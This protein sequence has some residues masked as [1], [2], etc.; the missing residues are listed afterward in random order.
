MPADVLATCHWFSIV[1]NKLFQ[2]NN[3]GLVSQVVRTFEEHTI[4]KL[5]RTFA[6][7]TVADATERACS[8][9]VSSLEVE[10]II[11][12]L[13]MSKTLNATLSHL[14][15]TSESAMLRFSGFGSNSSILNEPY[16][17]TRL[18]RGA[19]SMA[20]LMGHVGDG[21]HSLEMSKEHVESIVK[22]QKQVI[23]AF[24]GNMNMANESHGLDIEEDIMGDLC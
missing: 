16:V 11:A 3:S 21:N 22:N 5:S 14:S 24:K 19:L 9:S 2:D 8:R 17:E 6:A 18:L 20:A 7:L 13:I 23:G 15:G 1:S 12:S 4:H 10:L